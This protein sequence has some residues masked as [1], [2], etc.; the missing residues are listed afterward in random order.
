MGGWIGGGGCHMA[1]LVLTHHRI[2]SYK[3]KRACSSKNYMLHMGSIV[4]GVD[5]S[6]SDVEARCF[7][8]SARG[9]QG[10]SYLVSEDGAQLGLCGF[11][12]LFYLYGP[13]CASW[14]EHC[15]ASFVVVEQD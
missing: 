8:L 11:G 13:D 12:F 10:L 3:E 4:T 14:T 1:C 15:E 2:S 6:I 9:K 5:K 7:C